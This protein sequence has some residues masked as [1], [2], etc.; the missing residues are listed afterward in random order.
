L[1]NTGTIIAVVITVVVA[2]AAALWIQ[3]LWEKL[4]LERKERTRVEEQ[5]AA[6]KE[7]MAAWLASIFKA[8]A[9]HLN[10]GHPTSEFKAVWPA[11]QNPGNPNLVGCTWRC[12]E[13]TVE[14]W[15][16][17]GQARKINV[18]VSLPGSSPTRSSCRTASI[19]ITP[20]EELAREIAHCVEQ[21][22]AERTPV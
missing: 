17:T 18:A 1:N 3:L 7:F 21:L 15:G 2:A 8:A 11:G 6:Q 13:Y 14:L 12:G 5:L 22:L 16:N 20:S 19:A 4:N 10:A 9:Q